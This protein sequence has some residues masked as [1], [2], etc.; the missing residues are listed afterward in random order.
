[1]TPNN[2][3]ATT[4]QAAV[5]AARAAARDIA[6]SRQVSNLMI[7]L[8]TLHAALKD[9]EKALAGHLKTIEVATYELSTLDSDHPNYQTRK[10]QAEKN[11][12][13]LKSY[14]EGY[15]NRVKSDEKAIADQ[16]AEIAKVE[17]G[18][19]KCNFDN[20]VNRAKDLLE[21]RFGQAFNEGKYDA[22]TEA[23]NA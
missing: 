7:V 1:M 4:Y 2:P 20:M 14:T 15:E 10:E 19:W 9:S 13:T 5:T 12:E 11:I 18:E 23:D 8:R 22:T 17:S 6:R 3:I 21:E 16:E